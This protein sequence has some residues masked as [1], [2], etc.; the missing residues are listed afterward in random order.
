[1]GKGHRR[2]GRNGS[3]V[4]SDDNSHCQN[5]TLSSLVFSFA[6]AAVTK[7][8][9]LSDLNNRNVLSHHSGGQKSKIKVLAGLVPSEGEREN[10]FQASPLASG[11]LLTLFDV[12]WFVEAS[13]PSLPSSS[14]GQLPICMFPCP[15][16]PFL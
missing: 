9:T 2:R 7:D 5:P 14:H 11:G 4:E 13:P 8:Y 16:F 1:M 10:L 6:R 12:P 3:E 15:N